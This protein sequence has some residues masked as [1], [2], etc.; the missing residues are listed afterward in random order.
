MN[1][2]QTIENANL[3]PNIQNKI[4]NIFSS[5][6]IDFNQRFLEL[7]DEDKE[8]LLKINHLISQNIDF[9]ID[10][11]HEHLMEFK[12]TKDIL[13]AEPGR[14]E[15]LKYIQK[16]Y[17]EE[18][19][20]LKYDENYLA[21]R[22]NLGLTH[23]SV[24]IPINFFMN[25]YS[26]FLSLL[27]DFIKKE[28]PGHSFS[29]SEILNIINSMQKIANLDMTLVMRAY[30]SKEINEKERLSNDFI[31]RLSK[32]AE[33]RDENTGAHIERMSLYCM[34]TA[35]YLGYNYDFQMDILE[36]SPM[37]DI[38]KIS[39]PDYIL[40]KPGKLTDDEFEIMKTHTTKGYDILSNSDSPIMK[41]GAE[42]AL[43]HHERYDGSGYPYGLKGDDIPLS[44]RICIICDIFDAL[45]SKRVYKPAYSVENSLNIIKNEMGIGKYF[46]PV[47]FNAFIK[48]TDEIIAIRNNY[49]N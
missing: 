3:K 7:T 41:L 40:L 20:S 45:N 19:F 25:S 9:L 22:L 15:R 18:L 37:H 12:E 1:L 48:A 33:F 16:I 31:R 13:Q 14:I 43:S 49:M 17:F 46:D 29:N 23:L 2:S 8:N 4:K 39:I 30:Y 6:S 35:K 36:A 32:I 5:G 10:R 11:L 24:N 34:T 27:I 21:G 38:G 42:I 28:L 26:Y 47:I 44:G